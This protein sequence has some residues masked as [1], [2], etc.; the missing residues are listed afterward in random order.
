MSE[1]LKDVFTIGMSLIIRI[2]MT[3]LFSSI[4]TI[5]LIFVENRSN[6]PSIV[7]IPLIVSLLTK[8]AIG[9]W[10]KGFQWSLLD[11]AYWTSVLGTSY[12]IVLSQKLIF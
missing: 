2:I 3:L 11:I 9:D 10:D 1:T 7:M 6:L 8:Y 5:L 12:I 4:A